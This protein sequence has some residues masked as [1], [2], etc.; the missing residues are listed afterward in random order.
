MEVV[1]LYL[2]RV[3]MEWY[4]PWGRNFA[5]MFASVGEALEELGWGA[6]GGISLSGWIVSWSSWITGLHTPNGIS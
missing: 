1:K 3:R 2:S 4:F 5:E 6:T